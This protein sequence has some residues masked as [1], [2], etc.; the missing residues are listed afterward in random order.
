MASKILPLW[1]TL[2][3]RLGVKTQIKTIVF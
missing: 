3:I 2:N 1:T